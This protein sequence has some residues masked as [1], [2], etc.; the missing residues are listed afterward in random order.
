MLDSQ[1]TADD[2]IDNI[3]DFCDTTDVLINVIVFMSN[4]PTFL[5]S[6]SNF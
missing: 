5:F 6:G 1:I 3:K 4:L 2:F